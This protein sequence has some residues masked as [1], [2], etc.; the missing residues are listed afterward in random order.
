MPFDGTKEK[1]L[2]RARL[3][4]LLDVLRQ[5]MPKDFAWDFSQVKVYRGCGT[6][7]CALGLAM[8]MFPEFERRFGEPL[9]NII[10]MPAENIHHIFMGSYWHRA[11]LPT[12]AVTPRDVARRLEHYLKR[13]E[14]DHA[15]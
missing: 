5:P 11:F 12:A 10:E 3:Y 6:A 9:I 14:P 8:V 1:P 7:G 4:E 15:V 13:T 2:S